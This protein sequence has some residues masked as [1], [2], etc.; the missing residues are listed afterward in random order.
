MLKRIFALSDGGAKDL[1]KGIAATAIYNI[2]LMVPVGIMMML[3]LEM[4]TGIDTGVFKTDFGVG[5]FIALT[6]IMYVIIF[7]SQ[8]IQYDKTYTVAYEESANR[9]LTLAEKIRK[10]PLSFFGE[11]NLA[12]LTTTMMGDCTALERTFSNAIPLML[13]TLTMFAISAVCLI[14]I[15]WRMG[16]CILAP[17]PVAALIVIYARKAQQKAEAA[18]MDAKRTAYDGVQ[19]FLD[20]I[21]EIKSSSRENEYLGKIDTKLENVVKAS[22]KNELAPGAA[23]TTAQ[24]VL[25]FGLVL[26]L[27]VGAKLVSD[28]TLSI[29]YFIMYLIMA[30]RIYDPFNSCFMLMAEIFSAMV[31]IKRTKEIEAIPE[32]SGSRNCQN[33][34]YDIEFK[35]VEFA[36][37]DEKVL[38]GVSFVAK[39]GQ[40][41]ALVGPSGS[42]KSTVSRLASRFWDANKG[43]ITLGGVD[44]STIDQEVLLK[45]F[46]VVFQDVLLFDDTV[47]EN[48]RL[49]RKDA[50]DEEVI[51]AAKAACCEEFIDKLP[52]G[53]NTVIGENGSTL[54][55]GERQ[56]ISIARALL[57]NAPIILLDEA[58]ASMDAESEN[59]V[60]DALSVLLKNKTVIVIAHRMRTIANA[61]QI[62]VLDDGKVVESGKPE[63]L[64]TSG[65]L[66]SHMVALQ[67]EA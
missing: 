59:L 66:Y 5:G 56:R 36:Y 18:N 14:V 8:W 33:N 35:D 58:T 31:S 45:N 28:G 64:I 32:Q 46:S 63:Q 19:E 25:R 54:S 60:Q 15:D 4:L 52:E 67:K 42:G 34:G 29:P 7:I 38:K 23:T 12:D 55:G 17:V 21:Q 30:G 22:F 27:L 48:I 50:T 61:D 10:L 43:K 11:K 6:L 24:F 53:Y 13:G 41:T 26:V 49:G 62:I 20:T 37:N 2:L 16:L 57:K 39:Q 65:G 51:A 3:V 9:R 47:M 44:V 1:K 40:V